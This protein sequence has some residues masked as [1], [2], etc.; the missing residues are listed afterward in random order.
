[1]SSMAFIVSSWT[2]TADRATLRRVIAMLTMEISSLAWTDYRTLADSREQPSCC[3]FTQ[4]K[5]PNS[6]VV[7]LLAAKRNDFVIN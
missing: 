7:H 4:L 2:I 3:F 5:R 1:M 6:C